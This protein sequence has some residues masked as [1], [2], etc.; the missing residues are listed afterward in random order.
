LDGILG[1][2]RPN[3]KEIINMEPNPE[4]CVPSAVYAQLQRALQGFLNDQLDSGYVL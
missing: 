2:E 1:N 3:V 4:E